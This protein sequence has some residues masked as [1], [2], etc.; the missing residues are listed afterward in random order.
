M[1]HAIQVFYKHLYNALYMKASC[2]NCYQDFIFLH[3]F[4]PDSERVYGHQ[5]AASG[6]SDL[7]QPV[8]HCSERW[9]ECGLSRASGES[10]NKVHKVFQV[11]HEYTQHN[12]T[13]V[14][15]ET[16]FPKHATSSTH[17]LFGINRLR[18]IILFSRESY[19]QTNRWLRL[20]CTPLVDA[21]VELA[22]M[23]K[24]TE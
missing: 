24:Q 1:C 4:L 7:H 16:G 3:F 23:F 20:Y 15:Y 6:H 14:C 17:V 18:C 9:T 19:G 11:F 10:S 21:V 22:G 2:I 12:H 5:Y 8:Q 13:S